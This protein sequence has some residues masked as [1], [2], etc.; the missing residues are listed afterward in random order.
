MFG[1]P[2]Q[3]LQDIHAEL[4]ALLAIKPPHVSLYDLT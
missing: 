1:L 3:S 2:N 4:D